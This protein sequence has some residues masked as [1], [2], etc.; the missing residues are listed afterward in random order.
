MIG[1]TTIYVIV[2]VATFCT[3]MNMENWY[4]PNRKNY[5]ENPPEAVA[6]EQDVAEESEGSDD[7]EEEDK[8]QWKLTRKI[9]H[10]IL[11]CGIGLSTQLHIALKKK[12]LKLEEEHAIK[13]FH[14]FSPKPILFDY[15]N[16][17]KYIAVKQM[18]SQFI[19]QS[20]LLGLWICR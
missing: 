3:H 9:Q 10:W 13:E 8:R 15:C 19:R 17:G 18:C 12:T 14:L 1:R 16:K 11:V 2:F 4:D 6:T 5:I 7:S 20:L